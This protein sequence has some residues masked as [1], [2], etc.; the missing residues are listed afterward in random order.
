[1]PA[2]ETGTLPTLAYDRRNLE[3]DSTD[4]GALSHSV[5]MNDIPTDG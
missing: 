2:N 5:R 3:N 1:M 4:L